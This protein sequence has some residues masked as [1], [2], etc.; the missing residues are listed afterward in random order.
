MSE[1]EEDAAWTDQGGDRAVGNSSDESFKIDDAN[2]NRARTR[3]RRHL[4]DYDALPVRRLR[5]RRNRVINSEKS[6]E[7]S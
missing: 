5:T 3:A 4:N 1:E 2:V 7:S 6:E